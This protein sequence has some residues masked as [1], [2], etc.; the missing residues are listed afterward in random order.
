MNEQSEAARMCPSAGS[1]SDLV[2]IDWMEDNPA[3]AIAVLEQ[4]RDAVFSGH[5]LRQRIDDAMKPNK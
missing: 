4:E 3:L 5:M 1:V 2:R